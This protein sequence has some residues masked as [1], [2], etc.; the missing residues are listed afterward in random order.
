MPSPTCIQATEPSFW[1]EVLKLALPVLIV[2]AGWYIVSQQQNRRERRKEI[3]ELIALIKTNLDAMVEDSVSYF[4]ERDDDK[5]QILA[6]KMKYESIM[7]SKTLVLISTAGL[8][9]DCNQEMTDFRAAAMGP[10]FETS[11]RKKQLDD[12]EWAQS[13]ALFA[14]AV[15]D[16]IETAYFTFFKLSMESWKAWLD[17]R[18]SSMGSVMNAQSYRGS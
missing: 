2:I 4:R 6:G 12:P 10:Y 3:R 7:I 11:D 14:G 8:A 17:G 18:F 9:V 16:K 5:V 13:L 15:L 1:F